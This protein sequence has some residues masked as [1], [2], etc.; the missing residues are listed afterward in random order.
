MLN[1]KNESIANKKVVISGSGNVAQY[2]CQKIIELGGKVI[3][4]SDSSGYILDPDGLDK[5]KLKYI[6]DLKNVRRGRIS[7]YAQKYDC[8][9]VSNETPW[10]VKCDIALPCACLLY[11]SPSP[12][13]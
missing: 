9:F 12:R 2:A 11:T 7:E 6:F 10:S 4:L 1:V 8:T 5:E 13:D 3:T